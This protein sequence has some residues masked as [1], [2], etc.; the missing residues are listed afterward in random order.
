MKQ[1][2][3]Y[4]C[5]NNLYINGYPFDKENYECDRDAWDK[6]PLKWMDSSQIRFTGATQEQVDNQHE[7]FEDPNEVFN[8]HIK[9]YLKR[10]KVIVLKKESE[11]ESLIVLEICGLS[12]YY[13]PEFFCYGM[14]GGED[15]PGGFTIYL[16]NPPTEDKLTIDSI[17][18]KQLYKET[19]GTYANRGEMPEDE[20]KIEEFSVRYIQHIVHTRT[21]EQFPDW[22][23]GNSTAKRRTKYRENRDCSPS[24]YTL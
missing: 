9:Y 6:E 22:L 11:Y 20:H 2:R 4:L 21:P 8:A 7:I 13:N 19:D 24:K 1:Q 16:K 14:K 5:E 3:K 10:S 18:W 12:G 17:E 15:V 23:K